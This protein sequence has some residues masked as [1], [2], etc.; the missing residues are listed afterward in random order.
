MHGVKEYTDL[1]TEVMQ[2]IQSDMQYILAQ[3]ALVR[4][5]DRNRGGRV[6]EGV[7]QD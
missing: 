1:K 3:W 5:V 2:E 6:D 4:P 7:E